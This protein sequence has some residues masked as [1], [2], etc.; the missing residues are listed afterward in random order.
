MT[1]AGFLVAQCAFIVFGLPIAFVPPVRSFSLAGRLAA[2]FVTGAL[3][4]TIFATILSLF[5]L[6]WSVA[7]ERIWRG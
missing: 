2:A 1:A 5:D 3:A 7:V 4:Y 6:E